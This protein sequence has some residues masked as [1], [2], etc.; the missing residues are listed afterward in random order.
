MDTE[1]RRVATESEVVAPGESDAIQTTIEGVLI[2]NHDQERAYTCT[3]S[4]RDPFGNSICDRTVTINPA[5]TTS[6]ELELRRG[7][8]C[9]EARHDAGGSVSADCLIGGD[10]AEYAMIETGNGTIAVTDGSTR[11]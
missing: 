9:V 2:R 5:G 3:V 11:S 7:V 1:Q 10:P 4:V 8:Y 6:L